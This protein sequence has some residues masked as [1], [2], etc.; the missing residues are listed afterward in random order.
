MSNITYA[1]KS[2]VSAR[3]LGAIPLNSPSATSAEFTP[4]VAAVIDTAT[5]TA[6][7]A[8]AE[9]AHPCEDIEDIRKTAQ[10][11]LEAVV[12]TLLVDARRSAL[13]EVIAELHE[14]ARSAR[15]HHQ[16]AAAIQYENII[17]MVSELGR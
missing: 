3:E 15:D 6:T 1:P 5:G 11:A 14:R 17:E 12:P 16:A 9:L 10:V 8:L 13:L 7:E 4:E 2:A